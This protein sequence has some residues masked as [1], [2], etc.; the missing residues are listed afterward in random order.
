MNPSFL[1][2]S[3]DLVKRFFVLELRS[4][5]YRVAVD[6]L[7]TGDWAG[8]EEAFYRLI[9]TA[10]CYGPAEPSMQNA[11]FI[12]P[13]TGI[14]EKASQQHITFNRVAEETQRF[15]LVFAFDQSFSRQAIPLTEMKRKINALAVLGVSAFYYDSHA[16]FLF[17]SHEADRLNQ[18]RGHFNAI[19]IPLS[20]L[21]SSDA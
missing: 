10:D 17:A 20:R 21:V 11:I 1:G 5:G 14:R 8:T 4:L 2:D 6:P 12:D 9:G 7:F 18:L 16:R 15:N 3:Y 19:G 13:D